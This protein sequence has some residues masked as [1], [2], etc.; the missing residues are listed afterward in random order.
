MNPSSCR[1]N[2][3]RFYCGNE[4]SCQKS[5]KKIFSKQTGFV[6]SQLNVKF[7]AH[8][9]CHQESLL[10]PDYFL[11]NILCLLFLYVFFYFYWDDNSAFYIIVQIFKWPSE[12]IKMFLKQLQ[13]LVINSHILPEQWG[14]DPLQCPLSWHVRDDCPNSDRLP[15]QV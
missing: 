3:A 6:N 13:S 15:V 1:E 2:V 7:L 4:H 14:R 10:L 11:A 12:K 8:I 5:H 9:N